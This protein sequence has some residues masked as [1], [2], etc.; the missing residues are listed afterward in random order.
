MSG[1]Q[2]V[3]ADM[4]I[5]GRLAVWVLAA[6][7]YALLVPMVLIWAAWRHADYLA[8]VCD[9]PGLLYFGAAWFSTGSAFEVA[10]NTMDRWYLTPEVP[11]ANGV[12]MCDFLSYWFVGFGQALIA[13]AIAGDNWWVWL[14]A[15]VLLA[16]FPF[17]YFK[18]VA[19]HA[20]IGLMGLIVAVLAWLTF[21]DPVVF[22]M[23][24]QIGLTLFFFAALL[25]TGAQLLH[26]LTTIVAS[27]GAL[28]LPWAIVNGAT[29][30]QLSWLTVVVIL[31][32]TAIVAGLL[33]GPL[34]RLP[35]SPRVQ[36]AG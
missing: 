28:L 20:P 25:N 30:Q 24:A 26:G 36:P 4:D 16:A 7:F 18:Q 12:G 15:L 34:N 31:V 1:V 19:V 10:Q 8:T 3:L 23:F 9:Y 29:G 14:A 27:S 6:H 33:R 13:I 11:S 21:G 35:P 2:R 5:R 22:L 32:G 17:T